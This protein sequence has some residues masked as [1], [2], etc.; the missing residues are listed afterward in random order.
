MRYEAKHSFF[1]KLASIIGNYINHPLT[2]AKRHQRLQ[3]YKMA[4]PATFLQ[5]G[6]MFGKGMRVHG[7]RR[8]FTF[9]C[10]CTEN[11]YH[12]YSCILSC[13]DISCSRGSEF[14]E[15]ELLEG[16]GLGLSCK[17]ILSSLVYKY[18]ILYQ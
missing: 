6:L 5:K 8:E 7:I 15:S 11:T 17:T 2:L 10:T 12:I 13:S 3:C 14:R 9:I 18:N 1:K 16:A 4:C